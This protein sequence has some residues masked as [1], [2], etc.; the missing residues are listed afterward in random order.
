MSDQE[1]HS[2]I[3]GARTDYVAPALDDSRLDADPFRQFLTWYE[4]ATAA[5]IAE[6]NAMTVST[7]GAGGMPDA[8]V[9]LLRGFSSAGFQFFS[10]STSAKGRQLAAG[11]AAA[12]VFYWDALHRQVRVRGRVR[13]LP[14]ADA[15]AYWA[16]R[17][18]E[19]QI[20]AWASAQSSIVESRAALEASFAE[21]AGRFQDGEVPPPPDWTGYAVM[22]SEIEFWQGREHRLHDRIRYRLEAGGWIRERLAP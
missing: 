8:R 5:G 20:A 16:T 18:R 17:P 12:I 11:S 14:E 4:A 10:S 3:R 21:C 7:V 19:S 2:R 9:L 1:I 22:P 13:V 6:P 15:A